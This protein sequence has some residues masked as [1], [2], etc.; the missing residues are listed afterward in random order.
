[1]TG[2]RQEPVKPGTGLLLLGLVLFVLM[3]AAT[4]DTQTPKDIAGLTAKQRAAVVARW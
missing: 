1:M 4:C 2:E 3:A